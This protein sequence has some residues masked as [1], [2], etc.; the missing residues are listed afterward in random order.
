MPCVP[1]P[2]AGERT[3][4]VDQGDAGEGRHCALTQRPAPGQ[5]PGDVRQLP[6]GRE[7]QQVL[8]LGP[9]PEQ[10]HHVAWRRGRRAR[11]AGRP[12]S[13][14]GRHRRARP[15]SPRRRP[16]GSARRRHRRATTPAPESSNGARDCTALRR[17]ARRGARRAR[18][19]S[20]RRCAR[21]R[22][23]ARGRLRRR[24]RPGAPRRRGAGVEAGSWS[25]TG[26]TPASTSTVPSGCRT[27]CPRWARTWWVSPCRQATR[28]TTAAR[29]SPHSTASARARRPRRSLS[30]A[31]GGPRADRVV[32]GRR[33]DGPGQAWA[34]G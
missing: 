1:G 21:R 33:S 16:C 6:G 3:G 11:P 9:V 27:L 28:S 23:P 29:S 30:S 22:G 5:Q 31:A 18:A 34:R 19:R 8:A 26:S 14:R 7:P 10:P 2:D 32:A 13:P 17:R 4:V 12:P 20:G 15:A 24:G 25:A